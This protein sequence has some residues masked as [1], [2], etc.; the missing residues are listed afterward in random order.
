MLIAR[1]SSRRW[2]S[3][4][5]E[6]W[7]ECICCYRLIGRK[8]SDKPASVRERAFR[9][10]LLLHRWVPTSRSR[11]AKRM[12]VGIGIVGAA[13]ALER[14]LL[15]AKLRTEARRGIK[16]A[17]TFTASM[18]PV[19]TSRLTVLSLTSPSSACVA[20]I[21]INSGSCAKRRACLSFTGF[22]SRKWPPSYS[23]ALDWAEYA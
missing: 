7:R 8:C 23:S 15:R 20:L 4:S 2:R 5:E 19:L 18:R 17:P 9:H 14:H 16:R 3:R 12:R 21:E 10:G 1:C 13:C 6:A 11:C 22:T